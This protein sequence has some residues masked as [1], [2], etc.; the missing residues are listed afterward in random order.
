MP[1]SS[2]RQAECRNIDDKNEILRE[3]EQGVVGGSVECNRLVV[4][5]MREALFSQAQAAQARQLNS[6]GLV[7]DGL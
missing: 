1:L 4:L 6:L 5:K 7:M 2:D 3:L